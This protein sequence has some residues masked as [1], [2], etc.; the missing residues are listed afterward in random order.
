MSGLWSLHHIDRTLDFRQ[1]RVLRAS[2]W[3]KLSF[4]LLELCLAVAFAVTNFK[5]I[6]DAAAVLEWA[7]AF[8]F[9]FYVLS[10]FVDLIP[11][12]KTKQSGEK[13]GNGANETEMQQE[14]NDPYADGSQA[15]YRGHNR[16]DMTSSDYNGTNTADSQRTLTDGNGNARIVNGVKYTNQAPVASN[17]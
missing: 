4:I 11:A 8:I 12:V 9:T 15:G 1:H 16:S 2:F 7:V 14:Q 6:D 17:F 3:L 5:K 10:F 13:F